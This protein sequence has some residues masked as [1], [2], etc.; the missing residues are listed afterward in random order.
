MALLK[1]SNILYYHKCET[2]LIESTQAKTW[3]FFNGSFLGGTYDDAVSVASQSGLGN[4]FR[5]TAAMDRW[6]LRYTT[7]ADYPNG[8]D[9]FKLVSS[10]AGCF[11]ANSSAPGGAFEF[12]TQFGYMQAGSN[13]NVQI[14]GGP[15]FA[16]QMIDGGTSV[17]FTSLSPTLADSAGWHF[18]VW[19]MLDNGDGS[20][21]AYLSKDGVAFSS[22][23]RTASWPF[24]AGT[25][26]QLVIHTAGTVQRDFD[27][28]CV[29]TGTPLLTS[30]EI[31]NLFSLGNTLGLELDQYTNQFTNFNIS[32]D[33]SGVTITVSPNDD[34]ENGDG[35]TPF[36]RNYASSTDVTLT[37]PATS[38]NRC[39]AGWRNSVGDTL[40]LSR[41][42]TLNVSGGGAVTAHYEYTGDSRDDHSVA[43]P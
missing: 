32:S 15:T 16:M 9:G 17:D 21:S 8:A 3:S 10:I 36:A 6:M 42:F 13:H 39:F 41:S 24:S 27:E 12:N 5:E 2:D 40:S 26:T 4:A 1:S 30:D 28:V 22:Q 19:Q 31:D 38:E 7:L 33:P 14:R 23:T 35:T 34:D 29:W 43:S 18:Y 20:L 37:A 11:W 25:P